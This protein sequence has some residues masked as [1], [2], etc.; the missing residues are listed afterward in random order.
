MDKVCI[1]VCGAVEQHG[2][3]LPLLTDTIEANGIVDRLE[4]RIP[5]DV[6]CLPA[7]W[8]GY[9]FHHMRFPGSLTA[10]SD[11]HINLIVET[12]AGLISA[13]FNTILIINSHGGNKA[14]LQVALQK[15]KECYPDAKVFGASWW[16]TA[17]PELDAIKEAG[18]TGSGHAG[19]METSLMLALR[20]DL[21]KTD[22]FQADGT[23]SDS[24]HA[25]STMHF[26]RMDEFTSRGNYGDPTVAS[27]EKGERMLA[28]AAD[29]LVELVRDIKSGRLF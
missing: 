22:R 23:K 20:P 5:D 25:D 16:E 13:G 4:E 2:P 28:A 15:L 24:R 27:A 29:T 26:R 18:P 9:S 8:L 11:T 19:E 6:I 1:V 12:V 17:A 10:T 7:Q 21:V 3:H 14:D